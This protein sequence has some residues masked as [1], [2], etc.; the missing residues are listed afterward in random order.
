MRVLLDGVTAEEAKSHPLPSAHSIWELVLH[1]DLWVRVALDATQGVPMPEFHGTG[2]WVTVEDSREAAWAG[3]RESLF[4]S[5]ERLAAA[6]EGFGDDR[7]GDTVPGRDYNF[8]HLFHGIVQ[9]SL[10]HGGQIAL[11]RKAAKG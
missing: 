6:I 8:Y 10:Y 5:G 1:A 2:D 3:A 9:H 4:E 11:L 7:L